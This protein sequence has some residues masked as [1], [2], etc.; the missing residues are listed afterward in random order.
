VL[1]SPAAV[2]AV[3]KHCEELTARAKTGAGVR[4]LRGPVRRHTLALVHS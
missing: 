4:D 2:D 3:I 1:S